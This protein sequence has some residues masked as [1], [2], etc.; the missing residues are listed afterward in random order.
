[1]E[2]TI[3][4]FAVRRSFGQILQSILAHGDKFVVE[5]HG[6][7]VAVVVPIEVYEQWKQGRERFFALLESSQ[8]RA[9]LVPEAADR[10]ALEA[11]DEVRRQRQAQ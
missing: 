4:A 2:K 1:M 6:T 3:N 5:R 9:N 11:V 10:L 7:P 8:Q